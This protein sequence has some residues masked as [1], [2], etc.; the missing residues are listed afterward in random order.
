MYLQPL[1]VQHRTVERY[2]RFTLAS[3]RLSK[4]VDAKL[5]V[6]RRDG[7]VVSHGREGEGGDSV[8]GSVGKFDIRS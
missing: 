5:E 6:P 1:T 8:R 3:M 2:Q 4:V 7:K